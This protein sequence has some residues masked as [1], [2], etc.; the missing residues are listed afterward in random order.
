MVWVGVL[1]RPDPTAGGCVAA[2]AAATGS[3]VIP[4][5]LRYGQRLPAEGLDT[6]A[7]M[8]PQQAVVRVLNA[9]GERGEAG[10][11]ASGLANL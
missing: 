7:P 4:P 6:V 1:N 8:P 10:I 3:S 2:A 11:V 5:P 9:N